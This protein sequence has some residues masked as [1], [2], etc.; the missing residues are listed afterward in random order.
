MNDQRSSWWSKMPLTGDKIAS[1]FR[2]LRGHEVSWHSGK[3]TRQMITS[4]SDNRVS[5]VWSLLLLFCI[6]LTDLKTVS[7]GRVF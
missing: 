2:N 3:P 5:T 1:E 4:R 6:E 7:P